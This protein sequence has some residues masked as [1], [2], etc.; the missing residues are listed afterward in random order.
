MLDKQLLNSK[1]ASRKRH[2]FALAVRGLENRYELAI[3]L[4]PAR[5]C[6]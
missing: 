5:F 6:L 4:K 1:T 2:R 3:T